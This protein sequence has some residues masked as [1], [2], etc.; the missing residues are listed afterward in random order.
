MFVEAGAPFNKAAG[1]GFDGVPEPERSIALER[2]FAARQAPLQFEVATLADTGVA[3]AADPAGLRAGRLRERPRPAADPSSRFEP[4]PGVDV[5][6]AEADEAAA[7]L[8]AVAIGFMNPDMFDGPSCSR[9]LP[10]DVLDRVFGDTIAAPGFERY[11]AR[12]G[13]RWREARAFGCRT[14]SRS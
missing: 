11:L 3:R 13:G 7:W 6:R 4:V 10:R 14:E 1:L 8:D 5:T 12:R 9:N 2:A